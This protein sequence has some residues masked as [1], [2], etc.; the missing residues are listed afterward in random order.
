M[1]ES[2]ARSVSRL[3]VPLCVV[4]WLMTSYAAAQ[5]S[6]P[7]SQGKP[8]DGSIPP[9]TAQSAAEPDQP[10]PNETS[11]KGKAKGKPK[12]ETVEASSGDEVKA[13]KHPS[14]K[15]VPGVKLDF[16]GRLE[17]ETR[18][19]ATATSL[20]HGLL[21]WQDGRLGVEGKIFKAFTFE[22]SR[23]L[24][25]DFEASHGL[26]EKTAWKDVYVSA[27][28]MRGLTIDAGRFKIPFGRE[29]LT[30]ETNLDFVH[31]SLAARVLSPGRDVGIMTH[32]RLFNRRAEYQVGYFTR[33]GE[34]GRT[35]E[36][37]GGRDAVAARFVMKPFATTADRLI[38]PLEIGV[39][40]ERSH[41]DNR[42]GL[43]GRSVLADGIF[44]ERVYVNGLRRRIGLDAG[45]ESGPVSLSGEYITV[46]D[47]RSGMG[48]DGADLPGIQ[49]TAW[50]LAGTWALTGERKHGRLEPSHDFM[51]GGF[52]A[53]ELAVRTEGL[54]FKTAASPASPLLG[55]ASMPAGN[56]D[57]SATVGLN[58]YVNH[59]VKLQGDV[60]MEWVEDPQR[61]P[62][63]AT[64][65]RF[66]STVFLLQFRF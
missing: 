7:K 2:Q 51:R 36:T 11:K 1:V 53:F 42:L 44:F 4:A 55:P 8:A 26:S 14:W 13:P 49:A 20:D 61:S 38:A 66:M 40:A 41:V 52:G 31:R 43:R 3:I 65:G 48:F 15:P 28:V 39:A 35:S 54:G 25:Q 32:G 62:S 29:Q 21:Q 23:E 59:Y 5:D 57:H 10:P 50:Y 46:S 37:H 33:D 45:W 27:R 34:N 17:T 9:G 30:A 6:S 63:P 24:S 18:A 64:G 60:V 58:W 16:K 12:K 56:A 47:E 19:T 22:I